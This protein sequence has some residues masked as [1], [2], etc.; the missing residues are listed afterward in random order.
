A[1]STLVQEILC[2]HSAI[3]RTGELRDLTWMTARLDNESIGGDTGLRYP[4]ILRTYDRDRFR[5]LGEEYLQRTFFRRKLGRPFFVDKYPGNFVRTGLI[6]LILPNAKIVDVRRHPLD[7]CLSCFKNYFPEGQVFSHSLTDLGRYYADYIELMAHFDQVLPGKVHRIFYEDL[8]ANPEKEVRRL[9]D[10]LGV[11]FE[12]QCLRFYEKEQAIMTTSA[13][14]ART[15]IY[16]SGIG[17][18][19]HYEPWL[20]PLRSALGPVLGAYPG[21]PKFFTPMQISMTMRLA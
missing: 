14:Q 21:V 2:A 7:C 19:R 12:E 3:E 5:S 10:Y 15:P 13:E 17:S 18:W 20:E 1:G 4:E 16:K 8:V 6:H 9:F 11:P